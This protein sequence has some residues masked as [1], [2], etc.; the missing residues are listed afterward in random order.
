LARLPQSHPG[1]PAELDRYLTPAERIVFRTRMHP[2]RI[3]A[4]WVVFFLAL[5]ALAILD[6]Q[7]P[8]DTGGRDILVIGV[9]LL[10]V[11]AIWRTF[12]WYREWFVG[13]DRRLMLTL[14]ILTRKVAMIPLSKV[15]DMRYDRPPIGQILGYGSFVL[16]SAGQDQAFRVVHFVPHP[17]LLYRRIS[18][19]LFTPSETRFLDRP[20]PGSK[21]LPVQEPSAP[22][23]KRS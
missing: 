4:P 19:E 6:N 23:W 5:L 10:L 18:E 11:R 7:L 2:I 17:D 1:I 13:T 21:I 20:M 9:A 15:T 3:T 22:W 8:P 16:E 14:G 12:Q